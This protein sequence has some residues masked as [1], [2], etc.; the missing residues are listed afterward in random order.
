M[1]RKNWL[2]SL[3][4]L[5][6]SSN[7]KD[8]ATTFRM[9]PLDLFNPLHEAAFPTRS[10]TTTESCSIHRVE[11]KGRRTSAITAASSSSDLNDEL[12]SLSCSSIS[13]FG[14]DSSRVSFSLQVRVLEIPSHRDYPEDTRGALWSNW[15]DQQQDLKRN[16][17]EFAVDGMDWRLATEEEHFAPLPSGELVHP[18]T[19]I[20]SAPSPRL[21][22]RRRKSRQSRNHNNK[23]H[24]TRPSPPSYL[25]R[26]Q[27]PEPTM[28][29]SAIQRPMYLSPYMRPKHW[30]D[31]QGHT[32]SSPMSS[33]S[34]SS[35]AVLLPRKNR[36]R[37]V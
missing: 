32:A 3:K 7:K 37:N 19:W 10:I 11:S 16:L 30:Q 13:S 25:P 22:S 26:R 6:D 21:S 12:D 24:T 18:A 34:S 31:Y 17:F 29:A 5:F 8:D 4:N 20:R 2:Q 15:D 14:S 1:M 36:A 35:P 23:S 33:S 9:S 27:R 28:M